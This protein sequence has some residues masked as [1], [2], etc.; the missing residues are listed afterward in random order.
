[1][2]LID[3]KLNKQQPAVTKNIAAKEALTI[4]MCG[5]SRS[6]YYIIYRGN[7]LLLDGCWAMV[8]E[9]EECKVKLVKG[10]DWFEIVL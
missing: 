3:A 1:M 10:R 5:V 7:G 9:V 4:I 6:I 8:V 2:K